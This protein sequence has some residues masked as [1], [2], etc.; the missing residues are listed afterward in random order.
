MSLID[1]YL[2]TLPKVHKILSKEQRDSLERTVRESLASRF[3]SD[4][5][6]GK[7]VERSFKAGAFGPLPMR[8]EFVRYMPELYDLFILGQYAATVAIVG[9]TAERLCND[10]FLSADVQIDGRLLIEDQKEQIVRMN[11]SARIDLLSEWGLIGASSR[12]ELLEI[13]DARDKYMHRR[14]P[15]QEECEAEAERLF[16][17]HCEVVETEFGPSETGRYTIQDGMIAFRPQRPSQK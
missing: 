1:V 7:M 12:S 15:P 8:H 2:N 5:E 13:N 10:I 6:L 4:R 16:K 11:Q 9:A 3:S 17:L 14:R